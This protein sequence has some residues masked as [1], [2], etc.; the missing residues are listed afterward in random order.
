MKTTVELLT[1]APAG[2]ESPCCP[3]APS[4]P[5]RPAGP[6]PPGAPAKPCRPYNLWICK[7]YDEVVCSHHMNV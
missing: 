7:K 2:P 1:G 4:N 3:L 6:L 5:L